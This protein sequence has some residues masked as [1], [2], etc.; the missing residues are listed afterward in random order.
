VD[1]LQLETMI[2]V[3]AAT[4]KHLKIKIKQVKTPHLT[5]KTDRQFQEIH[6]YLEQYRDRVMFN[7]RKRAII[8]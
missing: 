8:I 1:Q 7:N 3:R 2:G 4:F 6:Q 5:I